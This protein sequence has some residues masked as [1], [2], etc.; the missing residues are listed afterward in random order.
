VKKIHTGQFTAVHLNVGLM[1]EKTIVCESCGM[2]ILKKN[3]RAHIWTKKCLIGIGNSTAESRQASGK[4]LFPYCL[5]KC[6]ECAHLHSGNNFSKYFKLLFNC[7][8]A[9]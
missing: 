6:I 5:H 1:D 2:S 9:K 4:Y 8:R 7:P 3:Y